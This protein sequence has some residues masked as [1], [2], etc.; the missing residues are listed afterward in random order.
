MSKPLFIV[1]EG[2]DGNGKTTQATLLKNWLEKKGKKVFLTSEPSSSKYGKRIKILVRGKSKIS[3]KVWTK[4]FTLDRKEHEKKIKTAL[5][6]K[7]IVICDRYVYSTMAYQLNKKEWKS[8]AKQFIK[9]D[10]VFILDVPVSIAI[11][12]IERR[13]KEK[14]EEKKYF[15]KKIFLKKVRKKFLEIKKFLD[16]NIKIIDASSSIGEIF[17]NIKKEVKKLL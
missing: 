12:R 1:L 15:E 17:E 7:K 14:G 3:K 8:Y 13:C 11:K 10:V 6:E 4:L 16:N 9:P 5:K 2:I